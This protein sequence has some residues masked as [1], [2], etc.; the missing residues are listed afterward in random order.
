MNSVNLND[1]QAKQPMSCSEQ[2]P[3]SGARLFV[4]AGRGRCAH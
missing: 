3:L 4:A 2:Q 1:I